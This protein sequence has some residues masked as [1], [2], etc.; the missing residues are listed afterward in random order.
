MK[1][2]QANTHQRSICTIKS[3]ADTFGTCSEST[4]QNN[5]QHL[6]LSSEAGKNSPENQIKCLRTARQSLQH[7]FDTANFRAA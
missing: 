2:T 1:N 6:P 5:F 4:K 3:S 7:N